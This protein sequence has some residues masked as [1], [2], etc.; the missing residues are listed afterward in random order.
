MSSRIIVQPVESYKNKNGE[1]QNHVTA[2]P[3]GDCPLCGC[4]IC[5]IWT[6]HWEQRVRYR[7]LKV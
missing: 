1:L 6:F 4:K 2:T 7:S 5:S 3:S